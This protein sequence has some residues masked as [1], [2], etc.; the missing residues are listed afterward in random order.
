MQHTERQIKADFEKLHQFLREEEEARLAVLKEEGEV[1]SR[2]ME[3]KLADITRHIS[4]LTDKITATEKAMDTEDTSFLKSYTNIKDRYGDSRLISLSKSL[5]SLSL[6]DSCL[7]LQSPVH[8][9]GPRAALRGT[10]GCGQT[11]GQPDVQSL[12]EDAGDGAVHSC[13]TGP[14]HCTSETLSL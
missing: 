5:L 9:A 10:D 1:K 2:I 12:G 8:T 7:S 3:E 6:T 11:P 4:T 14:Q 13:D